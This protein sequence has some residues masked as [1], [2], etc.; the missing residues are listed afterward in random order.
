M[1]T[2]YAEN[3]KTGVVLELG[4]FE[5]MEEAQWNI[6]NNIEYDEDDDPTEWKFFTMTNISTEEELDNFLE[7]GFDP[8]LGCYTDEC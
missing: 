1:I 3:I 6:D 7:C 5:T 2:V 4:E 8:Y